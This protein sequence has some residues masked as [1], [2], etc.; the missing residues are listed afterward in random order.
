VTP[1]QQAVPHAGVTV[2]WTRAIGH[3]QPI[4]RWFA[5]VVQPQ[6]TEGFAQIERV[7]GEWWLIVFPPWSVQRHPGLKTQKVRYLHPKTA[8][9]HF[10]AWARVN[11][12]VIDRRFGS[13]RP[14][15][16]N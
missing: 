11:W 2:R 5:S 6:E 13:Y 8:K 1:A 10:E 4:D 16:S 12:L 14:S 15:A 9:R 3:G 7:D